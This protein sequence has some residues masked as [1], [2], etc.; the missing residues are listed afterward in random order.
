MTTSIRPVRVNHI[1]MVL[2]D[3]DASVA[4]FRDLFGADFLMDLPHA[5]WHACLIDIGTVIFELFAPTIWLLNSRYGPHYL[6]IEYQADMQD[7]RAAVEERGIRIARDIDVAVHLHPADCLGTSFE[8]YGD[9]FHDRE[10][11]HLSGGKMKPASYWRD[12][13]PLGLTGLKGYGLAVED[14]EAASAFL[15]SF[16]SAE[17]LYTADRPAIAARATGL[18]VADAAIELLTPTGPGAL[19]TY[20]HSKGEGIYSTIFGVRDLEQARGYF[21]QRGIT[22]VPGSAPGSLALPAE[23][24]LGFLFEFAE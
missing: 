11:P 23:A 2:E 12:E 17:P 20:L 18:Q 10:Y 13:H 24:N 16:L 1:N 4:H 7:T 22:L 9:N 6:G 8:L 14:S 19:Q 15:G 5:A 21:A 3:Y